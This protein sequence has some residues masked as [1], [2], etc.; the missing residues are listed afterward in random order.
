MNQF[1]DQQLSEEFIQKIQ[2]E[3]QRERVRIAKQIKNDRRLAIMLYKGKKIRWI[4][5]GSSSEEE[6]EEEFDKEHMVKEDI[7]I[8]RIIDKFPYL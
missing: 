6:E 8:T 1:Y 2:D 4:K 5:I 7:F 3:E